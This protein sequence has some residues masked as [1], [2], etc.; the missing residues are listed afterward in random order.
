MHL[1]DTRASKSEFNCRAK[2]TIT[3]NPFPYNNQSNVR[4]ILAKDNDSAPLQA[5]LRRNKQ[6]IQQQKTNENVCYP[7]KQCSN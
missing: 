3:N 6:N 5:K 2:S 4:N 1:I 7:L